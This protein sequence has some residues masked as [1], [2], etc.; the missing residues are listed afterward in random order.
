MSLFK[1]KNNTVDLEKG[2]RL[3]FQ[4][5][6][7]RMNLCIDLNNPDEYA[8][9]N[10]PKE[11]EKQWLLEII[12]NLKSKIEESTGNEKFGYLVR[13]VH[14]NEICDNV[15]LICSIL[16]YNKL[17]TFSAI[18][19]CELL[20]TE[21]KHIQDS[22]MYDKKKY[23]K[24]FQFVNEIDTT[25]KSYAQKLLSES[26]IIDESFKKSTHMINYDFSDKNIKDRIENLLK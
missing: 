11:L 22:A 16:K 19:L 2:R 24:N 1:R 18:L 7:S 14:I 20:Q 26:I 6:G 12:S 25:V 10:V 13:L 17:D 21:K 23:E 15:S 4:Y 9:C 8:N 5:D 3:F